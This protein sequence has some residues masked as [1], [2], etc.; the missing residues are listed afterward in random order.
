VPPIAS[1]D[2]REIK[3]MSL[4][5]AAV[6]QR[7]DELTVSQDQIT[8]EITM[9]LEAAK[10]E[11]LDKISV[12]SPPPAAPPVRKPAPPPASPLR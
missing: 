5:L 10:R 8:R 6:R 3:A 9:R 1:A 7:V 12:L 11:I 2:P 4:G